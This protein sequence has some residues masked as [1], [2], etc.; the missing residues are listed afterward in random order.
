MALIGY[1]CVSTADQKLSLQLDAL[2][3]AG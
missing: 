3:T 1:A 2:N